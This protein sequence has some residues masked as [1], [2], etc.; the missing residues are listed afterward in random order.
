[1][2]RT[3]WRSWLTSRVTLSAAPIP[4]PRVNTILRCSA[5]GVA[6]SF[7]STRAHSPPW[8]SRKRL[9]IRQIQLPLRRCTRQPSCE[10][11]LAL[12]FPASAARHLP[13]RSTRQNF[14]HDIIFHRSHLP[15]P[16][17][18][19]FRSSHCATPSRRTCRNE[20]RSSEQALR[21]QI[22]LPSFPFCRPR[23]KTTTRRTR[24][25]MRRRNLSVFSS[26]CPPPR[27]RPHRPCLPFS[28]VLPLSSP[29][30]GCSVFEYVCV[31]VCVCVCDWCVRAHVCVRGSCV[32]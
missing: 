20:S 17:P 11:F 21:H 10:H 3:S 2:P 9:P 24:R 29:F 8:Q 19:P 13:C 31:C 23:L 27:P 12:S 32:Q 14:L 16:A 15:A 18:Q 22:P 4:L 30:C 1:V 6:P 26:C 7:P 28:V 5:F 25:K